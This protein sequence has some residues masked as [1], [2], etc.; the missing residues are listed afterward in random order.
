MLF[1]G[2][3]RENARGILQYGYK[4]SEKGYFGGGVYNTEC[5]GRAIF[6]SERKSSLQAG[7]YGSKPNNLFVFVNEVLNSEEWKSTSFRDYGSYSYNQ[8]KNSPGRHL[9]KYHKHVNSPKPTVED[10]KRDKKGRKYRCTATSKWSMLDEFVADSSLVKPRYMI[11]LKATRNWS[12]N[13]S[14]VNFACGDMIIK[15]SI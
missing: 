4:N 7:Y 13:N 10:Y 9:S 14:F 3:S 11:K 8:L 2:T 15:E 6:Y 12:S 5:T 1:H